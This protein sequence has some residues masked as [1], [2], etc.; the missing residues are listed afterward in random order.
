MALAEFLTLRKPVLDGNCFYGLLKKNKFPSPYLAPVLS[1]T[2]SYSP[3]LKIKFN[4]LGK[5]QSKDR[6][7]SKYCQL[8]SKVHIHRTYENLRRIS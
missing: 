7:G 1:P 8:A 6:T 4:V 5:W 3:T 2:E